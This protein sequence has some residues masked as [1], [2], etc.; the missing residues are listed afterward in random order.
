MTTQQ[1]PPPPRNDNE[2]T[3][4]AV[5]VTAQSTPGITED[6]DSYTTS[7]M[8][9]ATKLP[10][11][12]RET[13]Q[14]VTVITRQRMDDQGM[15]N[16]ID[17]VKSTP[18]L[19][20]GHGDGPGRPLFYSRGFYISNIS[21][22]GIPTTWSSYQPSS[23][24]GLDMYDHVEMLRGAAGLMQGAGTPGGAVNLVRKRPTSSFQASLVARLGSWN[25]YGG[26]ADL[27]GPLNAAGTVRGRVVA[28]Y[29]DA[30]SFQDRKEYDN[31]LF[32]GILEADL[33]QNTLLTLGAHQQQDHNKGAFWGGLPVSETGGHLFSNRSASMAYD[34]E[35]LN[36]EMTGVFGML[37][38]RLG[39]DWRLKF[40]A[41]KYWDHLDSIGT[42]VNTDVSTM[43]R[44]HYGWQSY[45]KDDTLNYEFSANGAFQLLSRKHELV[46]GF[47]RNKRSGEE[48]GGGGTIGSN[49]DLYNWDPSGI[50]R[51]D[52]KNTVASYNNPSKNIT[53]Q[54][55]FYL[56]TR[57]N[58]ADSL[59]LILGGRASC[60]TPPSHEM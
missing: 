39:E 54:D 6:S 51:P 50:A 32:Y 11:S 58:L 8:S 43:A 41:S 47:N 4:P 36:Q 38:H 12:I 46:L 42:Y 33:G 7:S 60:K 20:I 44:N 57:L 59:K 52:Y 24:A 34:W 37:E 1:L 19:S 40:A 45:R 10:L 23:V 16:L 53:T 25:H 2:V 14:S 3:L 48:H 15:N 56:T 21:Y 55:G 27:G 18:G 22:D 35:A 49:I 26:T 31:R 9:T 30:N 28:S 17:V 5:N 29:Q 13:P